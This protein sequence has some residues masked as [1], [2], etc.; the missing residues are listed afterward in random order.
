MV[1]G[2][3]GEVFGDPEFNPGLPRQV[4]VQVSVVYVK[5]RRGRRK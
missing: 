5:M 3:A 4:V 2:P 1:D